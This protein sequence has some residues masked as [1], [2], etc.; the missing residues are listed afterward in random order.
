MGIIAF[1]QKDMNQEE[2]E[3]KQNFKN[4]RKFFDELSKLSKQEIIYKKRERLMNHAKNP[5]DSIQSQNSETTLTE[6]STANTTPI[7]QIGAF[8]KNSSKQRV[9]HGIRH[10]NPYQQN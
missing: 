5:F 2:T 6:G 9:K 4:C 3:K 7:N 1:K 8:E 10:R